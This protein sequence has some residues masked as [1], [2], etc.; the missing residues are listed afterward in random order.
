MKIGK[1]TDKDIKCALVVIGMIDDILHGGFPRNSDG[2]FDE[3]DPD[4][5]DLDDG[6]DC[7]VFVERLLAVVGKR[8]HGG[9]LERVVFGMSTAMDNDVFD[10]DKDVLAWHPDLMAAVEAREAKR[11]A[12]TNEGGHEG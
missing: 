7:K 8:E 3:S 10:P 6:D 2:Q 5:F 9:S 11:K 1:A 4:Y 12:T